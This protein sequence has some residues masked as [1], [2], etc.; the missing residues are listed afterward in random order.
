MDKYPH[1]LI[2]AVTGVFVSAMSILPAG[3]AVRAETTWK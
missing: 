1:N 2:S 3:P